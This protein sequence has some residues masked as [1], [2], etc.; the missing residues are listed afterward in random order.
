M[1]HTLPDSQ[2]EIVVALYR[3]L[4]MSAE[5]LARLLNYDLRTVY[6]LVSRLRKQGWIRDVG[7]GFLGHNHCA[8]TLT[9]EGARR[10]SLLVDRQFRPRVWKNRM[11]G[12]E[13]LYYTN[14]FMTQLMV[15]SEEEPNEGL[16]E[17]M[18]PAEAAER[19]VLFDR[20]TGKKK[21]RL[22]PGAVGSY[23]FSDAGRLLFHLEVDMA[24]AS[25]WG[26]QD[27]LLDYGEILYRI[28]GNEQVKNIHVFVMAANSERMRHMR[29]LWRHLVDGM[30][31]GKPLPN[32]WFM[33]HEEFLM[34][35][36]FYSR[37]TNLGNETV[38]LRDLPLLPL[39]REQ[40]DLA[41]LGKRQ[42]CSPFLPSPRG[43]G[44]GEVSVQNPR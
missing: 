43:E 25:I 23:V 11:V 21:I 17:W 24:S 26:M 3:Y 1:Q 42:R 18:G 2:K 38:T 41:W 34:G 19:Y 37:W 16:V 39:N 35:G 15:W 33:T 14:E 10:A 27:Q 40:K 9:F 20:E 31:L 44:F 6:N 32:V 4:M 30:L 22:K 5:Q 13:R 8:Y 28:W 29:S 36:P 12:S 7:L